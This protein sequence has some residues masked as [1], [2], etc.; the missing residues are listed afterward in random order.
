MTAKNK[1]QKKTAKKAVKK[2]AVKKK[3]PKKKAKKPK[4]KVAGEFASNSKEAKAIY[5]RRYYLNNTEA[6][7]ASQKAAEQAQ[8]E[9]ERTDFIKK[10]KQKYKF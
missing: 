1:T 10:I 3:A 4:P 6:V 2:K 7:L 5:S 9:K 8:A